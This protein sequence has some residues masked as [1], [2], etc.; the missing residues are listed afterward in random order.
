MYRGIFIFGRIMIDFSHSAED[1]IVAPA[2]APGLAAISVIRLSGKDALGIADRLFKGRKLAN[3]PSH[4]IHYGTLIFEEQQVDE[5]VISLF[6]AP[7]SYTGENV[8]EISCH[9]S[10][11][12]TQRIVDACLS[13]GARLAAPGEFTRRAFLYG[14]MDLTQAEAVADLIAS[15]TEA[16]RKTALT[17]LRGGFSEKLR[18]LRE[19]L[20][21][22]SALIEL[23]LDFSQEDV[24]FADRNQLYSLVDTAL[25]EVDRLLASFRLGNAI[26]QGVNVAIVGKPNTGKSTL[27]NTLL[28]EDRAIVSEVAGTT[29]DTIEEVLNIAGVLFRLVDT[30][31]IRKDTADI[32][33]QIGVARS[34][35]KMQS[36]HVILYLFDVRDPV[37][38]VLSDLSQ[39]GMKNKMHIPV[40]NKC[41][42][43]SDEQ[44][45]D[46][47]IAIPDA[48]FISAK[49]HLHIDTLKQRLF[50]VVIQK[51]SL[52][53]DTLLTNIRH[54]EALQKVAVSLRDVRNGIDKTLPGDLLAL[55]IRLCLHYLGEITGQVTNKD[56]LDYVFSKFCIGK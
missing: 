26:K 50:D 11:Y 35:E 49:N 15:Q 31:G 25:I 13:E 43:L 2:T 54:M 30:A 17:H 45:N 24:A 5:V 36:A 10:P 4:T 52:S 56:I 18:L 7:H 32:I 44:L 38:E 12:I 55:D 42:L 37:D 21:K 14:K 3:Q 40:G 1:T 8:I 20:I 41:D 53:E 28:N 6:K 29:R 16:A 47:F 48:L 51:E 33:E 19:Q 34:L 23:E 27:L 22:F 46:K 39:P 9:G